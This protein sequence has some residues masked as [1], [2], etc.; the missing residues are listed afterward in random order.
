MPVIALLLGALLLFSGAFRGKDALH[1]RFGKMQ[2][3]MGAAVR[4]LRLPEGSLFD[5]NLSPP[6][7]S[8]TFSGADFTAIQYLDWYLH[9]DTSSPWAY[10]AL[11]NVS[12]LKW[13]VEEDYSVS[14]GL[15]GP[16]HDAWFEI[17][18]MSPWNPSE[19]SSGV[20]LNWTDPRL[21][22]YVEVDWPIPT[23]STVAPVMV[24][25]AMPE[26]TIAP[27]ELPSAESYGHTATTR[28]FLGT[29]YVASATK[30]IAIPTAVDNKK[31]TPSPVQGASLPVVT[32]PAASLVSEADILAAKQ[33]ADPSLVF[34]IL[35]AI[36]KY[37][38][39]PQ[40]KFYPVIVLPIPTFIAWWLDDRFRKEADEEAH[41]DEAGDEIKRAPL[42]SEGKQ[43]LKYVL[44]RM[45]ASIRCSS[46][47]VATTMRFPLRMPSNGT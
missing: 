14:P 25:T 40:H 21:R 33:A 46:H 10:D 43:E 2:H 7:S 23:T 39:I 28:C 32:D 11:Y 6:G 15:L 17:N 22:C 34:W 35:E 30:A 47:Y 19:D 31:E 16:G 42:D 45:T 37:L 8:L 24:I 5:W 4:S 13:F 9:N 36:R 41:E 1:F 44:L 18:E 29:E 3:T 12:S 27:T 38:D 20:F 26:P